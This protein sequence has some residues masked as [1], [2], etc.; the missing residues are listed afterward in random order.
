MSHLKV[1]LISVK[2]ICDEN[3]QVVHPAITGCC[4]EKYPA[5][6]SGDL[7]KRLGPGSVTDNSLLV[8]KK[9]RI[10]HF[11]V[12]SDVVPRVDNDLNFVSIS[13]LRNIHGHLKRLELF[14]PFSLVAFLGSCDNIQ[15]FRPEHGN[16]IL[17]KS[18]F[19]AVDLSAAH[20]AE[21]ISE[22]GPA[23]TGSDPT[24]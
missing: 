7:D 22:A 8:K 13:R 6:R 16:Q 20:L 9:E 12:F 14:F 5:V 1:S 23:F 10:S 17:L 4:R 18:P 15:I 11:N 24:A 21:I 2:P 19:L 3:R